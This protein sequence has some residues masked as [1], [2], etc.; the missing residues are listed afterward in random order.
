MNNNLKNNNLVTVIF[1]STQEKT[2]YLYK[3][4]VLPFSIIGVLSREFYKHFTKC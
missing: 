3:S 4:T 2:K 1:D